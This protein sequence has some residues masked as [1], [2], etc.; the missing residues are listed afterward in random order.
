MIHTKPRRQ[1]NTQ[2]STGRRNAICKAEER[3]RRS[4]PTDD[5]TSLL[6]PK[7]DQ[8]I[9]RIYI[10]LRARPVQIWGGYGEDFENHI[11]GKWYQRVYLIQQ[12]SAGHT[13]P[14]VLHNEK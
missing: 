10:H 13:Q 12:R 9:Q 14:Y 4:W 11:D 5:V 8:P 1:T 2:W 3:R 6:L 7:H